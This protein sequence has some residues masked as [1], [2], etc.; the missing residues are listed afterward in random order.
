F[1]R[2]RHETGEL[3]RR[4]LGEHGAAACRVE[5]LEIAGLGRADY[6]DQVGMDEIEMAD[7]PL[8][9][10]L[11]ELAVQLAIGAVAAG[12]PFEPQL[13]P[14][15]LNQP[16]YADSRHEAATPLRAGSLPPGPSMQ[17]TAPGRACR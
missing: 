13:L 9:G 12:D 4:S 8:G 15:F 17:A 11:G 6:L 16:G 2:C 3:L 10:I 14:V 5:C 7:Q 1:D